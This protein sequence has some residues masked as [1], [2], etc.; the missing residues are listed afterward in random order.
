MHPLLVLIFLP[1]NSNFSHVIMPLS[2]YLNLTVCRH[3]QFLDYFAWYFIQ[4]RLLQQA[5]LLC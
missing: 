3:K 5:G 1:F 2:W 4:M